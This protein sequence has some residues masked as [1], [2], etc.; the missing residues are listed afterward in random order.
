MGVKVHGSPFSGPTLRVV[1]AAHEKELDVEFVPVNL[2]VGDHKQQP[3]ISLNPFGQVPA[4]EDG[5]IQLF[6]SRAITKYIAY[7]YESSGNALVC[8]A[9]RKRQPKLF[10]WRSRLTSLTHPPA[11]SFGSL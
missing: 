5:D 4:F 10:G 2:R 9:K 8:Q 11:N 3:F 1:A 6:E 7:A